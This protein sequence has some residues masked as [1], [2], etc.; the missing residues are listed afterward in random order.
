MGPRCMERSPCK[1]LLTSFW[2]KWPNPEVKDKQAFRNFHIMIGRILTKPA[3]HHSGKTM[4]FGLGAVV[5]KH[6][7][8]Q[9]RSKCMF[10]EAAKVF[11]RVA[12]TKLAAATTTEVCAAAVGKVA[13]A[14]ATK[15]GTAKAATRTATIAGAAAAAM[16]AIGAFRKAA[17]TPVAKT[18]V[19]PAVGQEGAG[20]GGFGISITRLHIIYINMRANYAHIFCQEKHRLS[21]SDW[22]ELE[23][24]ADS[25]VMS[26]LEAGKF[27]VGSTMKCANGPWNVKVY[28]KSK[29]PL[30]LFYWHHVVVSTAWYSWPREGHPDQRTLAKCKKIFD[31]G[32]KQSPK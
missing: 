10:S 21:E 31:Q 25:C 2:P 24:L 18:E 17:P 29:T 28:H 15:A 11:K 19:S 16:V 4:V 12:V 22:G 27:P 14:A 13:T 26:E 5:K 32:G 30:L 1:P 3:R 23:E 6:G 7:F 9:S 20:G 8:C